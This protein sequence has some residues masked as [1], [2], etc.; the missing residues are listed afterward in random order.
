M[1]VTRDLTERLRAVRQLSES[2]ERFRG[3]FAHSAI[4]IALMSPE[5]RWL[6]VNAALCAMLG[7]SEAELLATTFQALTV[8]EDLEVNL[9]YLLRRALAGEIDHYGLQKR[10]LHKDGRTISVFA[11]PSRWFTIPTVARCTSSPRCW[12]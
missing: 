12:T 8:P 4:G 6:Q 10:Y 3:A 5:G 11:P 9:V 7:Y 1:S 2:E